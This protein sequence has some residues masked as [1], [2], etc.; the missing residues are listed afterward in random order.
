[1]VSGE[2]SND[3]I[4]YSER[5]P[6]FKIGPGS[7][8]RFFLD[9]HGRM[10]CGV[11]THGMLSGELVHA[12][13]VVRVF[14]GKQNGVQLIRLHSGGLHLIPQPGG[15]EPGIHQQDGFPRLDDGGISSAAAAQHAKLHHARNIIPVPERR[16]SG[17]MLFFT[18]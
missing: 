3:D 13:H 9:A 10:A 8:R 16:K 1:M 15:A 6:L 4:P 5:L 7:L 17:S 12:F 18:T 11:N 2:G 14:V